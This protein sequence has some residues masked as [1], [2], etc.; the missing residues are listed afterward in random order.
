MSKRTRAYVDGVYTGLD[1]LGTI[2]GHITKIRTVGYI[3]DRYSMFNQNIK[4]DAPL[5]DLV[6]N[7][8]PKVP[9]KKRDMK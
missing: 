3:A 4:V 7:F 1:S 2:L 6:I 9:P 5:V 8:D